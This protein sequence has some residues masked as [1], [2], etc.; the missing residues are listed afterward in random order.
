MGYYTYHRLEVES[1]NGHLIKELRKECEDAEYSFD[2]DG[3]CE[4]DSKWYDHQKD[5]KE[6]SEKHKDVLFTL[7]G[8]GES[9]EDLWREYFWNGKSQLAE[10]VITYDEFDKEKLQ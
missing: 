8:E 3:Y 10:A 5:M 9:S 1:G 6:F 4:Q 2:D 7:Y